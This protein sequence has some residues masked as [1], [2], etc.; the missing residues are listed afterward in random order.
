MKHKAL[1]ALATGAIAFTG[2]AGAAIAMASSA[3]GAT[4]VVPHYKVVEKTFIVATN[5]VRLFT[6]TC[7]RGMQPLGGGAHYGSNSFPNPVIPGSVGIQE[8]DI[9]LNRRGW[10][11]AAYVAPSFGASTFTAHVV[12]GRW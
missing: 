12:C 4:A 8:S 7:P 5:S 10:T 6:V 1:A 2:T 3:Q 9:S 11:V